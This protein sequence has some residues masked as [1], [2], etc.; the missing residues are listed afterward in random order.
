M[1]PPIN[2]QAG[3]K[4]AHKKDLQI[5]QSTHGNKNRRSQYIASCARHV[6]NPSRWPPLQC[7]THKVGNHHARSTDIEE[8]AARRVARRQC[9][10]DLPLGRFLFPWPEPVNILTRPMGGM[11]EAP[12]PPLPPPLSHPTPLQPPRPSP[13]TFPP[14]GG[15]GKGSATLR[16]TLQ[17]SK[18]KKT[19]T[20]LIFEGLQVGLPHNAAPKYRKMCGAARSA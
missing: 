4:S 17:I 13:R 10:A 12:H 11:E 2:P 3:L 20:P 16:A 15:T 5:E 8:G 9:R 7:K 1:I 14:F 19:C 18:R 6:C